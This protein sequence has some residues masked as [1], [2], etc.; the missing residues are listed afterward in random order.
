MKVALVQVASPA[1]E[2]VDSRVERVDT[3]LRQ[4]RGADLIVL[5]EL[6]APG[7][8]AF[9]AYSAEAETLT[10]RT[11]TRIRERAREFGCL[12]HVGSFLERSEG[13]GIHNTAVLVDADGN[14]IHT[15]RKIHVFGYESL[16]AQLLTPGE[17]VGTVSTP[18][19]QVGATTCYDL[20]F[21]AIWQELV[22]QGAEIV[23]VPAAWPRARLGHWRLFTACRAVEEQVFVIACNAVGSQG[24]VELGGHSR[25]VDPWGDVVIEC[26]TAEGVF[27]CEIDTAAV[28]RIRDEFPVLRDRRKIRTA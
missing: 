19:G 28:R 1:S 27:T 5:P 23:I 15:Y 17:S 12:I 21:P 16:E 18:F 20:R 4:A 6:W 24:T 26:G 14:A 11:M 10:G 25:V 13:G 3:L 8:F 22:D 2:P 7:Y 9:D